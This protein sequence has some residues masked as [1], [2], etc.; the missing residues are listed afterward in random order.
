M[1]FGAYLFHGADVIMMPFIYPGVAPGKARLRCNVTAAH[2]RAD[3]GYTIEAL[4]AVA[5][6]LGLLPQ[7]SKTSASGFS[8]ARWLAEGKLRGLRNAGLPFALGEL[9]RAGSWLGSRLRGRP[10]GEQPS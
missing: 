7:G 2:S 10:G 5:P 4:A 6:E 9:E 8:R 1:T 3:M